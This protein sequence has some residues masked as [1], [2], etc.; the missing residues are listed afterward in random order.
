MSFVLT[1][2]GA[3]MILGAYF[4]NS[5]PSHGKN[6]TL[7]L[8]TNDHYP[9]MFDTTAN[10][11]EASGGGYMNITLANGTWNIITENNPIEIDHVIEHLF[12]Q[13]HY[14]EIL[15][16]MDIMSLTQIII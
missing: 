5:W 3:Q 6:L 4:N 13:V 11:I 12:F 16:Y 1:T 15:L 7:K 2:I 14:L 9:S 8:F 10:Y